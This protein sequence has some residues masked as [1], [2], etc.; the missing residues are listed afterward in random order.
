MQSME[1]RGW[2]I[3]SSLEETISFWIVLDWLAVKVFGL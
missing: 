2:V 3:V 1:T